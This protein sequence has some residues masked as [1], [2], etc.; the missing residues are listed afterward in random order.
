MSGAVGAVGSAPPVVPTGAGAAGVAGAGALLPEGAPLSGVVLNDAMSALYVML[1]QQ[2]QLGM[3]AGKN[4]VDDN[5]KLRDQALADERAALQRQ[6]A[7]EADSGRGFFGSIGHLLGDVVDDAVHLRVERTVTDAIHDTEDAWNSPA[8]WNDLEKGALAVAK[9]AAVVASVAVTAA[10]L[11]AGAPVIAVVALALSLG[12]EVVSDTRV[13]GD[14]ASKWVGMCME[15]AGAALSL[16]GTLAVSGASVAARTLATVVVAGGA[17]IRNGDFA[18][19]A[20]Q[21]SADAEA[22]RQRGERMEELTKW[23]VDELKDDDKSHERAL[24]TLQGAMQTNDQ[25][26]VLAAS[27][28]LKG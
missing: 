6:K 10:T 26:A 17:H 16:G 13:F 20:Q 2:R 9:V 1:S 28:P 23:I 22:A 5:Q 8:F 18:A 14:G 19:N 21:A 24:Q 25:T 11:G 15:G 12:G 4:R 3:E 7:N 27:V